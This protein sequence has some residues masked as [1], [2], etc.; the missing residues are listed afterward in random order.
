[1]LYGWATADYFPLFATYLFGDIMA[2]FYVGVFYRYTKQRAYALKAIGVSF[3]VVLVTAVYTILGMTGATGQSTDSVGLVTGYIMAIGS[4]LLYISPFETIKTVLKTKSGAS[5]PF[6]MCL[7]GTTSNVL[8]M[9]NGLLTSD[10][11]IFLLG[12]VCAALGMVQVVLYLIYR[13]GRV[14]IVTDAAGSGKES[15]LPVTAATTPQSDGN[16]CSL[17]SPV[18]IAVHSPSSSK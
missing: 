7:A 9:I 8:W 15:V 1:M 10:I 12:T 5:I 16:Q 6:W 13:P 17:P 18:Y 4:V 2:I 14:Q 11:F 3:A